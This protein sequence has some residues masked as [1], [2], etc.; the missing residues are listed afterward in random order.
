MY[1]KKFIISS[2][3]NI[4]LFFLM[5]ITIQN[6][7]HKGKVKFINIETVP[8]PISFIL[9]SSFLTGSVLGSLISNLNKPNEN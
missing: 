8:L 3:A 1:Y 6:S 5:L 9:G 2:M 4:I 7:N